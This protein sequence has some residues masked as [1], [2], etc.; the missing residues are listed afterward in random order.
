MADSNTFDFLVIGAGPGGY[1]SAIRAAQLG[2]RTALVEKSPTLGGT[3]LNV[4]CIPSKA[5]L[6][7]TELIHAVRHRGEVHG[8]EIS[9]DFG[10]NL[11]RLMEQKQA[12]VDRLVGGVRTLVSKRGVEILHGH[13]SFTGP[14]SVKVVD[15]SGGERLVQA[16]HIAIATGSVSASL[17]SLPLDGQRIVTSDEAIAFAEVPRRLLVVG[18]GA[19]GL[20]LGSV[21]SRLGSEVTVVE[22]LPR[23]AATYDPDIAKLVERIFRK[24][25]LRIETGTA[26]T[27]ATVV[28][29]EVH[30]SAKKGSEE[31][32]FVA[33][34]VHVAVGRKPNTAGLGL[35]AIGLATD[36]KGRIP[37]DEHFSTAVEGVYA[38]GDVIRGPMLAHKAEEEGVALAERLAGGLGHVNYGVIPNVIYTDPEIAAVGLGETAAIEAGHQVRTG[39]FPLAANGRAIATD[40]TDGV[41]KVIADA[42]TDRVLGVQMVAR[43]ASELIA[44]A[45][46]HMEYGGS[47]EDI[48]RTVH[49]HPTLSEAFKE[50]A[51][52]VDK[53]SLHSL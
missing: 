12:V 37:V 44:A 30:L 28:G 4:G 15:A 40:A 51:L 3:C 42:V 43:N 17:P 53:R 10:I 14:G 31:V 19:I 8:L 26:V 21:W 9:P 39:S 18:G 46:T 16:R 52:A 29:D 27:S 25:G 49:A 33:D 11:S 36:E 20:E 41:I 48:A 32:S 45:V 50:A 38:I 5:L 34:R 35:E 13:A 24:Q 1:V 47:A 23:I 22:F 6:H 7:S 2:L